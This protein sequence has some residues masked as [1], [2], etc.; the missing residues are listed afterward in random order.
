MK[1]KP[2]DVRLVCIHDY[3]DLMGQE[4][5]EGGVIYFFCPKCLDIRAQIL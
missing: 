1:L 5:K 3:I 2:F 4:P